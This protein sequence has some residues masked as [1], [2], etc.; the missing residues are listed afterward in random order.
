MTRK[1]YIALANELRHQRPD[2]PT[3]DVPYDRMGAW[4]RGA[5]DEWSTVVIGIAGV[6]ASDN[7]RFDRGRFYAAC[8]LDR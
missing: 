4:E 5:Y 6:L 8:G 2:V 3:A 1:H 7:G